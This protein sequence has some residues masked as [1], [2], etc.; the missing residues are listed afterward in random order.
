LKKEASAGNKNV[1]DFTEDVVLL[2]GAIGTELFRRGCPFD[3]CVEKWACEHL[4]VVTSLHR[5]YIKSGSRIIYTGTF[6]ANRVRLEQYGLERESVV[7]NR[8]LAEAARDCA[9]EGV[10]VAGSIGPT[11]LAAD[12]DSSFTD[13]K[14]RKVF[15]EQAESLVGVGVDLLVIETMRYYA[16]ARAALQAAKEACRLPIMVS[17]AFDENALTR[18]GY[19]AEDVAQQ[20]SELG[21]SA[22]G[23]NCSPEPSLMVDFIRR[24]KKTAKVP[25]LAK[26]SAGIPVASAGKLHYPYSAEDFVN[27]CR[28]LVNAGAQLIGGCCGTSPAHIALLKRSLVNAK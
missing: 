11:G 5:D 21:A 14:L 13:A 17:F 6:G 9:P 23:C 19:R 15:A 8:T 3:S 7:I 12:Q 1:F 26:P 18:D 10:F 4:E 16:E 28:Q 27:Q 2:D 25:L 22:V 20:L 24:M